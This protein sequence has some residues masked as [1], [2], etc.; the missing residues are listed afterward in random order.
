M[1][2][3]CDN[4]HAPGFYWT[5]WGVAACARCHDAPPKYVRFV[6]WRR[7]R[8]AADEPLPPSAKTTEGSCARCHTAQG[9][10]E[11]TRREPPPKRNWKT[12]HPVPP[13]TVEA[14][15]RSLRDLEPQSPHACLACHAPHPAKPTHASLREPPPGTPFAWLGTGQLCATCHRQPAGARDDDAPHG[16]V[17]GDLLGGEVAVR[18][19]VTPTRPSHAKVPGGCVGCH[20]ARPR[21]WRRGDAPLARGGHT[22]KAVID[23]EVCRACHEKGAPR[24]LDYATELPALRTAIEG[25]VRGRTGAVTFDVRGGRMVLVNASGTVQPIADQ[26]L[27]RAVYAYLV[28]RADRSRGVHNPALARRLITQPLAALK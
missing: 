16:S 28:L 21:A 11:W 18:A 14:F 4:C 5:G 23:G 1:G 13:G 12:P 27:R 24:S 2:V 25:V 8:A 22:F 3:G 9:F 26:A 10:V 17:E 19:G 20:M 6:E 15:G 7:S